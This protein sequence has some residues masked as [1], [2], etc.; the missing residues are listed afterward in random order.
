M[1]ARGLP[2]GWGLEPKWGAPSPGPVRCQWSAVP[3][4]R[5]LSTDV[6]LVRWPRLWKVLPSG[7]EL[8]FLPQCEFIFLVAQREIPFLSTFGGAECRPSASLVCQSAFCFLS[9]FF[10]EYGTRG[11][12][13]SQC[14][15]GWAVTSDSL[16]G[17]ERME[18]LE[19]P[20]PA[21]GGPLAASRVTRLSSRRGPPAP[22]ECGRRRRARSCRRRCGALADGARGS[23]LR[24][25]VMGVRGAQWAPVWG[26]VDL[27]I[28][29]A[30]VWVLAPGFHCVTQGRLPNLSELQIPV[31]KRHRG[32]G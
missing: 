30:R 31:C 27:G 4:P 11:G 13:G 23:F 26:C 19:P 16:P 14:P 2:V 22:G 17:Q 10:A 12:V 5:A 21:V 28:R 32:F 24:F 29:P 25:L 7:P 3:G 15:A 9:Q 8:G 20:A 18:S 1:D 6:F